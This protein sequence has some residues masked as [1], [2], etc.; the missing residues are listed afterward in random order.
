MKKIKE[1][2]ILNL[3]FLIA[4]FLIVLICYLTLSI[5]DNADLISI[6]YSR[7]Y[8]RCNSLWLPWMRFECHQRGLEYKDLP[9]YWKTPSN[10]QVK[11]YLHLLYLLSLTFIISDLLRRWFGKFMEDTL[12]YKFF[13]YSGLKAELVYFLLIIAVTIGTWKLI[14]I[15]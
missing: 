12:S 11:K 6:D 4:S 13:P 9:K 1:F 3:P 2:F 10:I 8:E 14:E 15:I 5:Q 7:K